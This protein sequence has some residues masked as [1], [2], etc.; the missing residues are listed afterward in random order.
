M[1]PRQ[2]EWFQRAFYT[3]LGGGCAVTMFA[4]AIGFGLLI[5]KLI[6]R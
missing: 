6:F 4:I 5:G 3:V 2:E 1:N